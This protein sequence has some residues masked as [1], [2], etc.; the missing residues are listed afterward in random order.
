M[1]ELKAL[2]RKEAIMMGDE[3]VTPMTREE[4]ILVN[5]EGLKVFTKDEYLRLNNYI[6]TTDAG[7][8]VTPV[9]NN[10]SDPNSP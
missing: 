8:A 6:R 7:E 4:A 1:S 5:Q 3:N 2:T 9:S 10:V